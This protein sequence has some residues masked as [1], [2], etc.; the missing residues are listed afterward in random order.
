[1]KQKIVSPQDRWIYFNRFIYC[2]LLDSLGRD[3]K[4]Q[5]NS[6]VQ[7]IF[8]I[9]YMTAWR[10]ATIYLKLIGLMECFVDTDG[11]FVAYFMTALEGIE[12]SNWFIL[13][14]AFLKSPIELPKSVQQFIFN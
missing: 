6:F 3:W 10:Y 14:E 11:I 2:I 13:L 12:N 4:S 7:R 5:L 8:E 1:M 9:S